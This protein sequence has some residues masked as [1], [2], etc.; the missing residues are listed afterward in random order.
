MKINIKT[1]IIIFLVALL[2]AGL[3]TYGF[4]S[5]YISNNPKKFSS[6]NIQI[7]E[8]SYTNKEKTN[9]TKAID[10]SFDTVVEIETTVISNNQSFFF[11]MGPTESI[12]S[13]SGVVISEDGFIVTNEH[14]INGASG[15]DA[16]KVTLHS[17][18]TYSAKIIGSDSRTDLALLKIDADGLEFS[19]FADSDE[20]LM[21]EEVIAIGNPLGHGI[22]CSN[23]IISALE[24]EIYINN[25]YLTVIQTNAEVNG[26]NSGGGLFDIEGNIV[27]IVNAKSSNAMS[28]TTIEGMGYAIPSNT[29]VRIIQEIKDNGYV[30][31]RAALGIRVY[32]NSSNYT[33]KGLIIS[34]VVDGGSAQE[35]GLQKNDIII[36]ID[37]VEISSYADLSK[38][39]DKK[40]IGDVVTVTIIRDNQTHDFMVTLQQSVSE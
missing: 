2:G 31:D 5:L 21:G 40:N 38:E 14:V 16:V 7:N 27:G 36:A 30:K 26:G 9:Y 22:S 32:T 1:L 11:Y 17:G 3:G 15:P 29:V 8:V 18:D 25:V 13:G 39:L 24:K 34:D 35:A 19:S 6:S 28:S 4:L 12:M 10:K 37:D 23:G 20:L 33:S